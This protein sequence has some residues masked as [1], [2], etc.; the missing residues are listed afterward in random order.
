MSTI[1]IWLTSC[2]EGHN[3]GYLEQVPLP[4]RL[5]DTE[6]LSR[7]ENP[8][9]VETADKQGYYIALS[10]CW[11]L[12]QTYKTTGDTL[13][14]FRTSGIDLAKM[15]RC[16]QVALKMCQSLGSRFIWIDAFCIIQKQE[17]IPDSDADF[18]REGLK[19]AQYYGNAQLTIIAGNTGDSNISFLQERRQSLVKPC[20]LP[21]SPMT[22][23]TWDGPQEGLIYAELPSPHT[24]QED[25]L[26]PRQ[27]VFGTHQMAYKCK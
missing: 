15:S 1:K 11:G 6:P 18:K 12:D 21:F 27:L 7:G 2:S 9:L 25:I 16:A 14:A 23:E 5:I 10:Y 4:T 22:Y 20:P 19:M 13:D 17:G 3:C 8:L 26:S 24:L